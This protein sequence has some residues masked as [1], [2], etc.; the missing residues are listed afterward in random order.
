MASPAVRRGEVM[1]MGVEEEFVLV[2]SHAPVAVPRA[3]SV[4]A[5]VTG[6]QG[7]RVQPEFYRTQVETCTTPCATGAQTSVKFA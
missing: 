1:T 4:L 5:R 2:G 7:E 6:D 3:A